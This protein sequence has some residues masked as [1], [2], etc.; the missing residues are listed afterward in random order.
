MNS[1]LELPEEGVIKTP[2]PSKESSNGNTPLDGLTDMQFRYVEGRLSG[3]QPFAAG[4]YAGVSEKSLR[5]HVHRLERHPKIREAVKF[6]IDNGV[7]G[8]V[9]AETVQEG[10]LDAVNAAGTSAELTMAWREL[11]KLIGAYAPEQR[12]LVYKNMTYDKLKTVSDQDLLSIQDKQSASPELIEAMDGEFE[13][14][15][16]ACEEP[17]EV[18][19]DAQT[20]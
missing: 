11:G 4:R 12:E 16:K 19:S 13:V 20:K 17:E 1:K 3:M 15:S 2:L 18:N 5:S 9:T 8:E 6:V 14:L 7:G 10:F